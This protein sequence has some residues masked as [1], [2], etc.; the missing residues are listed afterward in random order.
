VA[1]GLPPEIA[2]SDIDA[3]A[4]MIEDRLDLSVLSDS[5]ELDKFLT[6]FATLYDLE[7][8]MSVDPA[9]MLFSGDAGAAF[10][11]D[12]LMSLAQVNRRGI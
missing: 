2:Q 12:M 1:L 11:A 3:Q 7:N 4:R 8:N 10:G 6:R 9:V 5:Q